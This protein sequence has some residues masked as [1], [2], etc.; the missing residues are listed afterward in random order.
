L[1]DILISNDEPWRKSTIFG[2]AELI[3]MQKQ[4]VQVIYE[5]FAVF[6]EFG[7]KLLVSDTKLSSCPYV[8]ASPVLYRD[9][10]VSAIKL[11]TK[12]WVNRIEQV[13]KAQR[14][15]RVIALLFL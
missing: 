10:R 12:N 13:M 14:K 2:Y 3:V 7:S 11:N 9:Q 1:F 8:I 15:S 6:W 4:L 5:Q